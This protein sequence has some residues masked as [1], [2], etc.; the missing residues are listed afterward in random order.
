M[1]KQSIPLEYCVLQVAQTGP[2]VGRLGDNPIADVVV[3]ES[4]RHYRFVGVAPRLE[5]GRVNV[6]ALR[7]DEWIVEPGLVYVEDKAA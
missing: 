1:W 6:D 5:N 7:P 4:G 3:D 2:A